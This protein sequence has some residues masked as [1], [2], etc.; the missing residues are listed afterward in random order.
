MYRRILVPLDGSAA[1]TTGL[2][3]ALRLASEHGARLHLLHV[4]D[5]PPMRVEMSAS[6]SFEE[7]RE[8]RRRHG[9]RLLAAAHRAA[10]DAGAPADTAL[11]EVMRTRIADVIIEEAGA[12]GCDLIVMGTQ[13]RRGVHRLTLGSD[14][15]RVARLSAVP[16]MLVR[17]QAV[18]A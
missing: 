12:C 17:E 6:T 5:N 13:R 10:A 14:A 7:L 9:K 18:A 3:E 15:G 4:V 11:R 1:A 8:N 16:V 2:H